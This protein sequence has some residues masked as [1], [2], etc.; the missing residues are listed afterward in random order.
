M[1]SLIQLRVLGPATSDLRH[2]GLPYYILLSSGNCM[3]E[4]FHW[5][6]KASPMARLGNYPSWVEEL[7]VVI[8][9]NL[10]CSSAE[11]VYST[12]LRLPGGFFKAPGA[13]EPSRPVD[14]LLSHCQAMEIF[15]QLQWFGIVLTTPTGLLH[16]TVAPRFSSVEINSSQPS[17]AHMNIPSG[18]SASLTSFTWLTLA[19]G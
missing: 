8:K 19:Q 18:W 2:K 1:R 4:R 6:I 17:H 13:F 7:P 14:Y 10:G 9:D 12:H 15:A 11:L 16:S 5:T 3:V